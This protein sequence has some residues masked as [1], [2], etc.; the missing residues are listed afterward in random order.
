MVASDAIDIGARNAQVVELTI[1]ESGQFTNGL[2]VSGPLLEG[3]ADVHLKFLSFTRLY[4]EQ[5]LPDEHWVIGQT[6]HAFCAGL[7]A[8]WFI[9]G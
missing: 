6:G 3:L 2:L 9:S 4:L 1:V 8:S 5:C 7:E